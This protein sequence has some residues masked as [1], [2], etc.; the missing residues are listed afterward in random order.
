M[1][2]V[3]CEALLTISINHENFV[4]C[5]G[6]EKKNRDTKNTSA[7]RKERSQIFNSS[8]S[9]SLHRKD[10]KPGQR[11]RIV[12]VAKRNEIKSSKLQVC[13]WQQANRKL[14][15]LS[16]R[17]CCWDANATSHSIYISLV[18]NSRSK[19]RNYI[20]WN[21][22]LQVLVVIIGFSFNV[23]NFVGS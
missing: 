19:S 6:D 4:G 12:R 8:K 11:Q 1:K 18:Q 3:N 16:R 21:L 17:A 14:L 20:N 2:A 15:D 5:A 9:S 10:I 13:G 22:F 23:V 7:R